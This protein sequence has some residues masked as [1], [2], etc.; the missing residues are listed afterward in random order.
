MSQDLRFGADCFDVSP[1]VSC[2]PRKSTFEVERTLLREVADAEWDRLVA[3]VVQKVRELPDDCRQSGDD[4]D[5]RDVW[6][7]YCAQVQGEE[8]VSFGAYEQL[9]DEFCYWALAALAETG[10]ALLWVFGDGYPSFHGCEA[11]EVPSIPLG[12]QVDGDLFNDLRARVRQAAADYE[13]I[14][15]HEEDS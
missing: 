7:E 3:Q 8:S 1:S 4:S 11:G 15:L 13:L 12:C 10:K 5:S 6:E 14:T 9:V 2:A